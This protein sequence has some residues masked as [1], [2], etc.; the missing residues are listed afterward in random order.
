MQFSTKSTP[1][2][3]TEPANGAA[4]V[5]RVWLSIMFKCQHETGKCT[6]TEIGYAVSCDIQEYHQFPFI[7][8]N[9][10]SFHSIHILL[11]DPSDW[12]WLLRL[13]PIPNKTLLSAPMFLCFFQ[14]AQWHNWSWA[15]YHSNNPHQTMNQWTFL[16]EKK[17][18]NSSHQATTL[19]NRVAIII[20]QM[21]LKSCIYL[22]LRFL[23]PWPTLQLGPCTIQEE[24]IP[25]AD[26]YD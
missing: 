25:K 8:C 18:F 11:S 16:K 7:L 20:N 6:G 13:K 3:P 5:Q 24:W 4:D 26:W 15:E 12:V 17:R 1:P 23:F 22:L 10:F 9:L 14:T 2:T 21:N 19:R